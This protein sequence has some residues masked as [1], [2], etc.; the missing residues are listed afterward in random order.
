[1]TKV[2]VFGTFDILHKGHLFF[3]NEA[4]GQGDSLIAVVARDKTVDELKG[5]IPN[6]SYEKR[7]SRLMKTNLVVKTLPSDESRGSWKVIQQ[8]Y[9]DIICLGHDQNKME[10]SLRAWLDSQQD[11]SPQIV[12]LP[13]YKR[14]V[15]SSTAERQR[16][17][18]AFYLLLLLSMTLM[19]F[20]WISGK[21]VSNQAPFT[22][23]VFWRF[24]LSLIPFVPLS[25]H[26]EKFTLSLKGTI[27]TLLS[28]LSLL[29]YNLLFFSG[30]SVGLAGKGGVIVTTLNPLITTAFSLF[31][32]QKKPGKLLGMGLFIGLMGGIILMEPWQYAR[33]ELL[34]AGNLYFLAAAA[35]W[36]LLTIFSGKAQ[37]SVSLKKYNFY[38]YLFAS[39][40]SLLLALPSH[41]FNFTL[42][43]YSFWIN[44]LYLSFFV[45]SLATSLYF[46]ATKKLGPSR[47][48]TFTF[49][50][51]LMAILLSWILL[52][53]EGLSLL[54]PFS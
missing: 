44:I 27:Y 30:L 41:P 35:F 54:R 19:A 34:A 32:E 11:Y 5:R 22:V 12:I 42:L 47:A 26:K 40:G 52:K 29:L 7:V 21:V 39:F 13:P 14:H 33:T 38:L 50:I 15:Y 6:H 31:L 48:S 20:S 9:P 28:A 23:L 3:L 46:Q 1:M 53:E 10:E 8:E 17:T 25:L 18:S 37:E 51:P 49:I 43:S 2:M 36:A 45:S 4:V 16:R 24:L